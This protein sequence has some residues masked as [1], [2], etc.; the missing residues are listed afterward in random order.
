MSKITML[1]GANLKE[2]SQI[3]KPIGQG[4]MAET[5]ADWGMKK[6]SSLDGLMNRSQVQKPNMSK[7]GFVGEA[8]PGYSSAPV[9]NNYGTRNLNCEALP[10]DYR[11]RAYDDDVGDAHEL[12]YSG[13]GG[14]V[15][16]IARRNP[17]WVI[18]GFK[19]TRTSEFKKES[20]PITALNTIDGEKPPPFKYIK[21]MLYPV[22]FHPASP[23]SGDCIGRCS[24]SKRCLCAVKN[25]G[26]IPYNR[27]ESI[28]EIE[29]LC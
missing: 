21:K 8:V 18:R 15:V 17:V 12:I 6:G 16:C 24:D 10:E 20:L 27:N 3:P 28:V 4:L 11:G 5:S 9:A 7:S 14:N 19:D 25:G 29:P 2:P 26:E 13:Q 1:E 23:K 22:G